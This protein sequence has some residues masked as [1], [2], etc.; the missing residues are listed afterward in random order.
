MISEREKL[1]ARYQGLAKKHANGS[2]QAA[3]TL[4]CAEC[5][6]GVPGGL[7]DA[8]HCTERDCFLWPVG[9][10]ARRE[11]RAAAKCP[12]PGGTP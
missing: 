8:K 6:G 4:F 5:M 3:V 7:E 10:A 9:P 11:R 12:P 1:L 2:R